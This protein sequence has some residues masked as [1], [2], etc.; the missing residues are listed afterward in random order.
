MGTVVFNATPVV[1]SLARLIGSVDSVQIIHHRRK[2]FLLNRD[3]SAESASPK[4][5]CEVG[6]DRFFEHKLLLRHSGRA[7]HQL[8]LMELYAAKN[9]HLRRL[10]LGLKIVL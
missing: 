7:F 8:L 2:H 6:T 9:L 10:S 1:I 5:D 4:G 3:S